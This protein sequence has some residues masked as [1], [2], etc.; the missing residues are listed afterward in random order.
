MK[1]YKNIKDEIDL[2]NL[3]LLFWRKKWII[4]LFIVISYLVAFGYLV[5]KKQNFT[6]ISE[7]TPISFF[8]ESKYADLNRID[9]CQL[10]SCENTQ[11]SEKG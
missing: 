2:V 3:I 1:N 6:A 4:I 11:V 5:N 10:T 9:I 7:V 8:D